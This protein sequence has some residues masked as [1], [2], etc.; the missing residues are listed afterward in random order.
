MLKI[1]KVVNEIGREFSQNRGVERKGVA[2]DRTTKIG[3]TP[4]LYEQNQNVIENKEAGMGISRDVAENKEDNC[5]FCR[6][7]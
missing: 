5:V 3:G 4:F 7:L 1:N 6:C 2:G